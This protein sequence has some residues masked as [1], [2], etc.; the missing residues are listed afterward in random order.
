MLVWDANMIFFFFNMIGVPWKAAFLTKGRVVLLVQILDFTGLSFHPQWC[1]IRV[2]YSFLAGKKLILEILI[3]SLWGFNCN[4]KITC[5]SC[6]CKDVELEEEPT[7]QV[8]IIGSRPTLG[9]LKLGYIHSII[10]AN[11]PRIA[12]YFLK[13]LFF[14]L[15]AEYLLGCITFEL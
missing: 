9:W 14:F 3:M 12:D 13:L 15:S 5:Q 4:S 8:W 1:E 2:D 11:S 7:K 10:Q 6:N